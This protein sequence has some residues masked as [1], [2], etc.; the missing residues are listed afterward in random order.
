MEAISNIAY[1]LAMILAFALIVIG[2]YTGVSRK[3]WKRA[4]LMLLVAAVLVVNVLIWTVPLPE[5]TLPNHNIIS[6][7][8][9]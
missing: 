6:E 1:S 5:S 9:A 2:L 4:I 7:T 8:S 3:D